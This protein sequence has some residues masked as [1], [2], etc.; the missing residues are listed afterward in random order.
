V[1][2]PMPLGTNSGRM[3]SAA[4]RQAKYIGDDAGL[5]ISEA[6]ACVLE[7]GA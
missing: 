4:I 2:Y 1:R 7:E 5:W 6:E 3:A